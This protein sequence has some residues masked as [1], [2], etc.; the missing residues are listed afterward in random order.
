MHDIQHLLQQRRDCSYS[1]VIVSLVETMYTAGSL[2]DV[3]DDDDGQITETLSVSWIA[4]A[5]L[6]SIRSV[7]A[8]TT[9]TTTSTTEGS[10]STTPSPGG[11]TSSTPIGTIVGAVVG[12]ILGLVLIIAAA[13]FIW[14]R[15][16][17]TPDSRRPPTPKQ[18]LASY[19]EISELHAGDKMHRHELMG[20]GD[21]AE[22]PGREV[23]YE[24]Q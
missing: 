8:T 20:R 16:K 5:V 18:E 23:R 2:T 17:K 9:A 19:N 22:L 15:T 13:L 10:A 12:G 4:D 11:G 3:D 7:S 14:K 21:C 1:T 24:L 6:F